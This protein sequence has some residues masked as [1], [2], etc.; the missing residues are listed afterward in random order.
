MTTALTT[1]K[2]RRY[3][4][5]PAWYAF[6]ASTNLCLWRR[7]CINP[8]DKKIIAVKKERLW[9]RV[10]VDLLK[11]EAHGMRVVYPAMPSQFL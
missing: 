11:K 10:I 2:L 3:I 7:M 6:T 5:S 9:A 4:L 8:I 1:D